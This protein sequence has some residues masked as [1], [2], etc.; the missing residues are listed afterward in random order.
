MAKTPPSLDQRR[1][2]A[3][4]YTT[5]LREIL[6]V[7][8]ALQAVTA[9]LPAAETSP[10]Q[11]QVPSGGAD[12]GLP[13]QTAV[14]ARSVSPT[15]KTRP[16]ATRHLAIMELCLRRPRSRVAQLLA[17]VQSLVQLN[18]VLKA[19]LPPHVQ[20][21]ATLA[22]LDSKAWVIQTDSPA[23]GTRLR[24]LLPSLRQQLSDHLDMP[25][26]PLRIRIVPAAIPA[27]T[28]PPRRMVIT[29]ETANRLEKT[30]RNLG[31]DRL[32][33]ALLRLVEH[34]RQRNRQP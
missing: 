19:F 28:P 11:P 18:Q 5:R 9:N 20:E 4:Q 8:T 31:D 10:R 22:N 34:A 6:R 13:S 12:T 15:A 24:Y 26:P 1:L 27:P 33:A 16:A 25:V 17:K 32:S 23:W 3:R 29:T 30:A 14:R 21:H 2:L 7:S